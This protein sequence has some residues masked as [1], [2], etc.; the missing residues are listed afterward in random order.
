MSTA[1]L[2]E[3]GGSRCDEPSRGVCDS[4]TNF[5]TSSDSNN[6]SKSPSL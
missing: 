3:V 6:V 5:H 4:P 1:A 2:D